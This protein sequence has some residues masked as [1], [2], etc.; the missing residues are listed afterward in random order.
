MTKLQL[1]P[2]K[3]YRGVSRDDPIRFYYWPVIGRYYRKR[4]EM[5]LDECSGGERVLEVGF[6]TGLSFL[7]LKEKYREIYGL[8][9]TADIS[10]VLST[11]Q[12]MGLPLHLQN[13]NVLHLPFQDNFFD[14]ILLISILEHLNPSEL[15]AA[16]QELIRVVKPNGQVVIGV[17]V[18]RPFMVVMFRL[19]GVN[20]REHHF[21]T[22]S[23]VFKA[24][25]E[26]MIAKRTL[27]LQIPLIGVLYRVGNFQ[28][29]Q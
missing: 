3:R 18:E 16:F 26:V 14:T 8:D 19:M 21:S 22:D 28:C 25:A 20:I 29:R 2:Y 6:G 9:L 24:A 10:Q 13:G 4:V 1:L 12:G 5:C 23:D 17:P 11:F 15:A 7:N 27:L